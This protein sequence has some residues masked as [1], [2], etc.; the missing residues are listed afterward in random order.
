MT[1]GNTHIFTHLSEL[2]ERKHR[3]A[4]HGQAMQVKRQFRGLVRYLR[5]V[6]RL[7]GRGDGQ[8]ERG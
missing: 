2:A 3:E 6:A 4:R 5:A 1:P 8:A 7:A